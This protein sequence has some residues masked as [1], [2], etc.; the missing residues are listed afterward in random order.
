M[1]AQLS[2]GDKHSKNKKCGISPAVATLPEI[3]K[4]E[5]LLLWTQELTNISSLI[6]TKIYILFHERLL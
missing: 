6:H 4:P 2:P 5:G 1:Q 3:L